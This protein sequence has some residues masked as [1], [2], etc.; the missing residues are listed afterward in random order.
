[1]ESVHIKRAFDIMDMDGNGTISLDEFKRILIQLNMSL[2]EQ[3]IEIMFNTIDTNSNDTIEIN[4]LRNLLKTH[5]KNT[6][7]QTNL[8]A[9]NLKKR[10]Q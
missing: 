6:P 10:K 9:T 1:M 3:V 8:E 5:Y 2:D 4:E 7:H